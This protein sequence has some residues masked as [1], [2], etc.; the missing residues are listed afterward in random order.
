M[1]FK[2]HGVDT[3]ADE[4][5]FRLVPGAMTGEILLVAVNKAGHPMAGGNIL[6]LDKNGRITRCQNV[7]PKL[8]LEL[9][10]KGQ[11][12]LTTEG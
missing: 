6:R 1:Q 12:K 9:N 10:H 4:I 8:G 7:S 5:F 11:V 3:P 2:I